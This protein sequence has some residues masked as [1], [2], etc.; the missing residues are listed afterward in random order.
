[1]NS[2]NLFEE[3]ISALNIGDIVTF[4]TTFSFFA[5]SGELKKMFWKEDLF[6][7]ELYS[8]LYRNTKTYLLTKDLQLSLI[9]SKQEHQ[10]D[11]VWKENWDE[12]SSSS[13]FNKRIVRLLALIILTAIIFPSLS[14]IRWPFFSVNYNYQEFLEKDLSIP[15]LYKTIR[16]RMIYMAEQGDTWL[17]PANAWESGEG[18]CEEFA[19]ICSDYLTKHYKENFLVGLQFED[20]DIGHAVV[21]VKEDGYFTIIDLN[22][23]VVTFGIHQLKDSR[24]LSEAVAKYTDLP[25]IIYAV[26]TKDGEK[27]ELG[28]VTSK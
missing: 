1:M 22:N 13:F 19:A 21:F 17:T 5:L 4:S 16:R 3:T 10:P 12:E 2:T 14:I 28:Y 27:K 18:D 9:L 11:E 8:F 6:C 24:T 25:G 20:R 26:P 15:E 23:S 7:V